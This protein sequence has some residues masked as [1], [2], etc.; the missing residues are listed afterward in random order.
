MQ[1][2]RL[3]K[4]DH[5]RYFRTPGHGRAPQ[6]QCARVGSGGTTPPRPPLRGRAPSARKG[7]FREGSPPRSQAR[8]FRKLRHQQVL[9]PAVHL[10]QI[11]V[12]QVILLLL[13]DGV[14]QGVLQRGLSREQAREAA[15][16]GSGRRHVLSGQ[17]RG[18]RGPQ[19]R[20][21][22]AREEALPVLWFHNGTFTRTPRQPQT[23]LRTPFSSVSVHSNA[24]GLQTA[25]IP[26]RRI[27]LPLRTSP[28]LLHLLAA[29]GAGHS[30]RQIQH[31]PHGPRVTVLKVQREPFPTLL[32]E[33]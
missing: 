5:P 27:K 18:G 16:P 32:F 12:D 22:G 23:T 2:P 11:L 30:E 3:P 29:A 17:S 15:A 26:G 14:E 31:N 33:N 10:L 9:L 6:P 20:L 8:T 19:A 1:G 21:V 25:A 7:R 4:T 28:P 24:K 13:G